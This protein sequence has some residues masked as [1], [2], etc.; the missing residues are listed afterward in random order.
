MANTYTLINSYTATGS[1]ANIDFTSIPSTYTDLLVKASLRGS[2]NGN[3][4]MLL[5]FNGV[6]T[7]YTF[8]WISGDGASAGSASGST[9]NA[10]FMDMNNDTANTFSNVEIYIPNYLSSNYKSV[11]FDAVTENN[12]TTAYSVMGASLWSNTA[13]ITSVKLLPSPGNFVQYSTA[14][15]YGIKNS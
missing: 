11:S 9:S 1:V 2:T 15:L 7:G 12:A 14:Y 5:Q 4:D 3:I 6:T 8:R 13:A 10:G